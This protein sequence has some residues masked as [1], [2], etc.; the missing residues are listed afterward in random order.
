[1][2][3][4]CQ[5]VKIVPVTQ[6]SGTGKSKT[7]DKIAT[8]R[9]LLPI[10]LRENLD[11]QYFAYPL[12]DT[13]VR[14]HFLNAP[15]TKE[16]WECKAYFRAFLSSLFTSARYQAQNFYKTN[17]RV[18]YTSIAKQF[19]TFFGSTISRNRFYQSVIDNIDP[20]KNS[21]NDVAQSFQEFENSLKILCSDW[22]IDI[23]PILVSMDEVHILFNLRVQDTGSVY[24]LY[25][26]LK[27][28]LSETVS[29][30]VCFIFL[31]TATSVSKLAPSK[32]VAPCMRERDD[33]RFLPA[34]IT[35]LP[36]D[37]H[38]A[39]EPI[40]PGTVPLTSVGSLKF[41]AKF[42]RPMFYATYLSHTAKK[43]PQAKI[44]AGM[45]LTIREKLS[46]KRWPPTS[47]ARLDASS[48]AVLSSRFLLDLSPTASNSRRYEEEQVRS[49][50]RMLYS[51]HQDLQIMVTGSSPEP[52]I[53][54]ASAQ[55]MHSSFG[56][57]RNKK[58]HMNTWDLLVKFV[59]EGLAPQGTIGELIG[60][61][62]SIFAMDRAIHALTKH[63]ELKYQ[64]PV[65]VA[66]YYQALLT[67]DAWES[68]RYSKPANGKRLS[69]ASAAKTF[70]DAFA[71]AY[72]HFSHYGK[73]ND[74]TPM[75]DVLAWAFW[76]RGTAI[77][78]QPNQAL[79][80]RAIPI[81]FSNL[82]AASP[83]SISVVLEQDK[84]S[85][86]ANPYT[87]DIQSAEA[88][89]LFSQGNKPPYIA[90]V[91][92]YA[93][94]SDE[95]IRVPTASPYHLRRPDEDEE[96]P[97]YQIDFLGLAAYREVTRQ[98]KTDIQSM[99]DGSKDALSNG[100]PREYGLPTLGQ[101]L[102][103]LN[104]GLDATV[105]VGNF[106]R[107]KVSSQVVGRSL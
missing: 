36:F 49:H 61:V 18:P 62:L 77:L 99:I 11:E 88:L 106:R 55:I 1:M 48:I 93:L 19:Y 60:R 43:E 40:F 41:T 69:E 30:A 22:P 74:A 95:G 96:A 56:S 66:G 102:P 6:S 25:S 12:T 3:S 13:A 92:C 65:T 98:M 42:G 71:S 84:T 44:V 67:D 59:D 91:H 82:G 90:A 75:Q 72:F 15:S 27:S 4:E 35:E 39:L 53:A 29:E 2:S 51:V 81:L 87:I 63:C 16:E 89:G 80:D 76:L 103:L 79:T 24:D 97:R 33:E 17:A 50:L 83:E 38:L 94:T 101:M 32:E 8:E 46:G 54:E 104:G 47:P 107:G 58:A 73:A 78:C 52:L 21:S 10:C 86:T 70:E 20:R 34:P 9:I 5:S 85:H 45:M 37:V 26:R 68:L 105:W 57:K 64:T 23:C 7:I 31:S 100:H 28:V 14:D